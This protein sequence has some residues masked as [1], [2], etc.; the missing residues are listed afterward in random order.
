ML[1][2]ISAKLKPLDIERCQF[3]NLPDAKLSRW[4]AGV[5]ADD[6]AGDAVGQAAAG[7]ADT[8]LSSGPPKVGYAT[9]C[10]SAFARTARP[11]PFGAKSDSDSSPQAGDHCLDI[12]L[13]WNGGCGRT[14]YSQ[15]DPAQTIKV[16]ATVEID[17]GGSIIQR[18]GMGI[19]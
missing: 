13:S 18:S 3:V 5:T 15:P 7:S 8:V 19:V 2:D 14:F 16:G 10:S 4:G 6:I 12:P 1:R 17:V 9:R 11:R